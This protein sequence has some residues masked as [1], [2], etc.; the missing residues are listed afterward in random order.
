MSL[1]IDRNDLVSALNF[2]GGKWQSA[3][4]E[5]WFAVSDPATGSD[6][7]RVPDSD[8]ADAKAA[9][10]AAHAAFREWRT[11][12]A[13]ERAQLLK[14]WHSLKSF[15]PP[16]STTGTSSSMTMYCAPVCRFSSALAATWSQWA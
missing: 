13:R 1:T 7:A 10:D 9:G 8:T 3:R 15:A 6:F 12:P 11:R 14:R 5:R 2:I 16:D 4:D